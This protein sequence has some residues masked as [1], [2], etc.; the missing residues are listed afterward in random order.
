MR[1]PELN[2]ESF[3]LHEDDEWFSTLPIP[4]PRPNESSTIQHAD[5]SLDGVADYTVKKFK[6]FLSWPNK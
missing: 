6:T 5:E 2:P 4:E 3:I 1:E